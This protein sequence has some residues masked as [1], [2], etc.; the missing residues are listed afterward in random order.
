MKRYSNVVVTGS[1]ARDEIMN[2][3]DEFKNYFQPDKLHQINVSFVV[4]K[5]KQQLGGTATN[6][7]YGI[8]YL[9]TL[10]VRIVGAVG[11]D[12][13]D[14]FSFFK[15]QKI[16]IE[17]VRVSENLYTSTGKV[18]TD[19][20]D[21]QIWSFYYGAAEEGKL[22]NPSNYISQDS[23]V[24][25]SANHKDSFMHFQNYVIANNIAYLYDPGMA[26]TWISPNELAEGVS[27]AKW[28][29]GNDYEIAQ[30][31]K[32][33]GLKKIALLE[34]GV[35]LITTLGGEG[36]L[37]ENSNETV[38]VPGIKLENPVDP[39]GAGDAWRSGF[40][41]A[42]MEEAPVKDAL[43]TA[44]AFASFAVEK[45]GTTNHAPSKDK[46]QQRINILST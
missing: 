45:Y 12:N 37:Y 28:V 20:A 32:M 11:K 29:V 30:L 36:V 43:I 4:D 2:F 44:N 34:K 14:F 27:H 5:L 6:I 26:L 13:A 7:A 39:T 3:P 8:A 46:L 41:S 22:I 23:L 16:N 25:I 17:G 40:I 24:V 10:D 35:S 38:R 15:K 31:L 33:T 1:I 42:L 18:M 19:M 9:G 21:N